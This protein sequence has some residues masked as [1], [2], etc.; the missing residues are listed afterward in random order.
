VYR[1]TSCAQ[2]TRGDPSVFGF[3]REKIIPDYTKYANRN[4]ELYSPPDNISVAKE[5]SVKWAAHMA[6]KGK[7]K[8]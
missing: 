8:K 4:D 7:H 5:R 6:L 2:P 1:V 3:S